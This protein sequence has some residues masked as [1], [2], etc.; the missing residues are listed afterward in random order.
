VT[1]PTHALV[2]AAGLGTRLQPLTHVRAKPAVPLAGEPIARR[3]VR[4]LAQA[5]VE[6][7]TLNL[8][9]LPQTISSVLGDGADLGVR[10]RYS[11]EQPQILGSAGGIRQALDIIGAD[12]FFVVNGDTLTDFDLAA[13][14][15]AH[16][17]RGAL[18]TLALTP[19]LEPKK[20]GGVRLNGDGTVAEFVRRGRAAEGTHHFVG[21]QV[22]ER[23]AFEQLERGAVAQSI[24]GVYDELI[25]RAPGTIRGHVADALFWD[26]GTLADYWR[27][28][29]ELGGGQTLLA[30]PTSFVA[31][32]ATVTNSILWDRVV[33]NDH[34]SLEQC[35]VTDGVHIEGGAAFQQCVLWME[36][37]RVVATPFQPES[38]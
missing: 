2:L 27:T 1:R 24:G 35:I 29:H 31:P 25:R 33:V 8:H 7:V 32:S 10:V 30:G 4:R 16:R 21:V 34:A 37:G 23:A 38:A 12:T 22:A 20:Y 17:S 14:A 6:V 36:H 3:I 9:Y 19:N 26:I 15:R 11:W 28:S 13:L 18:V 5:G